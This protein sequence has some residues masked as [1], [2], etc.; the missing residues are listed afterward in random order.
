M[1]LTETKM[2]RLYVVSERPDD[3]G[4]F[5]LMPFQWD[6]FNQVF[7]EKCIDKKLDDLCKYIYGTG[8]HFLVYDPNTGYNCR[9]MLR[10]A[11]PIYLKI[12]DDKDKGCIVI[13]CIAGKCIGIKFPFKPQRVVYHMMVDSHYQKYCWV[14]TV[15]QD[16][17]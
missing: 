5:E 16:K 7:D 13:P 10:E 12:G 4:K 2:A 14:A 9:C 8:K 11:G 1:V 6:E 3:N 17:V 15:W